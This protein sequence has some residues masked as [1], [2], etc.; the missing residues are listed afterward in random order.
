[1]D[2]RLTITLDEEG[3]VCTIQKAGPIGL[4]LEEIKKALNL[5]QKK[6]SEIR[7]YLNEAM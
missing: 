5:A 3:N 4:S 2:A 7:Q 1:L 6:V